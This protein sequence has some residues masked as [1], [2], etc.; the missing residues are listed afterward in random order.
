M[1]A[2]D[3]RGAFAWRSLLFAPADRPDRLAKAL[4]S[5][6]DAV[7][8]DLEDAVGADRKEAAREEARKFAAEDGG[9]VRV[10]RVNEPLSELGELDLAALHDAAPAAVMVPKASV[11]SVRAATRVVPRV[12]ALVETAAGVREAPRIAAEEGVVALALGVVDLAAALGLAPLPG[13]AELLFCRS[14]LVLDAAAAGLPAFDGPFLDPADDA[15]GEEEARRAR[16]LGFR[17][18]LCIHPCQLAAVRAAFV[19]SAAEVD[20]AARVVAAYESEGG[21]ATVVDGRMVDAA[22]VKEARR[23]VA[24]AAPR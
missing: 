20:R 12:V 17:G 16:A 13:G 15:G 21:G 1:S 19:A 5:G 23:I 8:A 2:A 22:V 9:P 18:K 3:D 14:S 7:I 24:E 4:A 11:E 10:V 6:A